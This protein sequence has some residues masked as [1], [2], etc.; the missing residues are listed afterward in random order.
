[1]KKDWLHKVPSPFPMQGKDGTVWCDDWCS[2]KHLRSHHRDHYTY[3]HGSCAVRGCQ[4][5]KFTWVS[6]CEGLVPPKGVKK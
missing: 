4:C 2:C 5:V 6:S 3:G 1:M